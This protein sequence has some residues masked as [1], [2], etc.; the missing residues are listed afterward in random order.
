[1]KAVML[2]QS[3]ENTLRN[4]Q[5]PRCF[6]VPRFFSKS[7][8]SWGCLGGLSRVIGRKPKAK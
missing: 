5:A 2:V 7:D 1:M 8:E 4:S 6:P 3:V